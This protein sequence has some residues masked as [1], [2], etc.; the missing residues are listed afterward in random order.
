MCADHAD[1]K[2]KIKSKLPTRESQGSTMQL[3]ANDM[4]VFSDTSADVRQTTLD[5]VDVNSGKVDRKEK[6]AGG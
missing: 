6:S 1:V 4:L 5:D 3:R 2:F